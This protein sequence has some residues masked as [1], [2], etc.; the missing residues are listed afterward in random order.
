MSIKYGSE[1]AFQVSK[2]EELDA[3]IEFARQR[4]FL[5]QSIISLKKR[6]NSCVKKKDS[7]SKMMEENMVLIKEI[8]KL[9]QELKVN[10]KKCNNLESLIKIKRSKSS[11]SKRV[12][13]ISQQDIVAK[14]DSVEQ[15]KEHI[16]VRL[17]NFDIK[18]MK[19]KLVIWII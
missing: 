13:N 10:H 15:Y 14:V 18:I 11:I 8:T 19:T 12:K 9:R 17:N 7:Y 5:E 2:D 3:K 4:T 6:V 16:N 1:K